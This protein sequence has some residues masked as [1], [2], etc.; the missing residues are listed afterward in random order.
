MKRPAYDALIVKNRNVNVGAFG[1]LTA[2]EMKGLLEIVNSIRP[3]GLIGVSTIPN[4][5]TPE[6]C[7]AHLLSCAYY[8]AS[9]HIL[10]FAILFY[11]S[12]IYIVLPQCAP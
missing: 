6:V 12:I 5:F 3:S 9:P 1:F 4:T 11:F 2:E 8:V 7:I 10:V